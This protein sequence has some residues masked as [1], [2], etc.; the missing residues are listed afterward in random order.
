[1][2]KILLRLLPLGPM[3]IMLLLVSGLWGGLQR[4]GWALPKPVLVGIHG[5]LMVS[6]FLGTVIGIERATALGK[7]WAFGGPLLTL[8]GS[9]LVLAGWRHPAAL[10]S[11]VL[12]SLLMLLVTLIYLR[13]HPAWFSAAIAGGAA[14]WAIGN[15]LW[16]FGLPI[17]EVAYWWMGFLLLTIAGERL[18]LSRIIR[19]PALAGPMFIFSTLLLLSGLITLR[20]DY[21]L[22]VRL[23]AAAFLV[24]A[25]WMFLFD[26]ARR[27][28]RRQG[29]TRYMALSMLGGYAWLAV[30]GI[31]GLIYGGWTAGSL[32]DA[33]LHSVF[34]GF[35]ITMI[36]G[37][38]PLIL[39]ALLRRELRFRSYFY[40]L[41]G[42]LHVSLLLRISGDLG[43]WLPLRQWGGMLNALVLLAF[44]I[45]LGINV[46]RSPRV[47]GR[48]PG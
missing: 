30:G 31:L 7:R 10:L 40:L 4:M 44:I 41:L 27:N 12:G 19:L 26:I 36:F 3:M 21:A 48:P 9:V 17:P 15:L 28:I 14:A 39:P 32:Y 43:H 38:G 8:L 45:S 25:L 46:L 2:K 33:M 1:M 16:L 47:G 5:P 35:A 18:E 29:L 20:W 34:V 22:G 24:F 42:I 23:C 13:Q 11:V 6:G 37:H